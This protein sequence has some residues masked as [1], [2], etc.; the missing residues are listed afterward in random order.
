MVRA[1][2]L[3]ELRHRPGRVRGIAECDRARWTPLRA[4]DRE[5]IRRDPA[6][7]QPG[8]VLRLADP[9][10]AERALLHDPLAAHRHVGVELP[11]ERLGERVLRPVRLTISE[12]VEI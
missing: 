8:T 2:V 6:A 3:H 9:L 5:L 1:P 7:L 4:R 12:P 10:Y 11:V